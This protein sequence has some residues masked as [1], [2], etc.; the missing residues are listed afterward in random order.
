MNFA[1]L[2][3]V[4]VLRDLS[5]V[6][7]LNLIIGQ[8]AAVGSSLIDAKGHLKSPTHALKELS[9]WK[10]NATLLTFGG[11]PPQSQHKEVMVNGMQIWQNE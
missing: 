7:I 3:D 8:K 10:R 4:K 2:L 9:A 5:P 6:P 1:R 11:L